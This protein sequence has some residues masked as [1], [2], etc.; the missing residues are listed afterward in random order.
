MTTSH[1]LLAR[2]SL[3]AA[4]AFAACTE[5]RQAERTV[6]APTVGPT[7]RISDSLAPAG[8]LVRVSIA[9][10]GNSIA[11]ATARIQYDSTGVQF[12]DDAAV[13][14]LATRISNPTPGLVRIAAIAPQGFTSGEIYAAHFM[15]H[16]TDALRSI[17]LVIDELHSNAESAA[18]VRRP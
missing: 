5:P 4:F 8:Q 16:R 13:A 17:R 12:V 1:P 7:L 9:V 14:D 10:T 3:L 18:M 6:P 11:S 2:C 15:V